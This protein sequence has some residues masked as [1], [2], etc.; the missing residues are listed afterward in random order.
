MGLF[1][2]AIRALLAPGLTPW[3]DVFPPRFNPAPLSQDGRTIALEIL[4]KYVCDLTFYREGAPGAPPIPFRILPANFHIEWPDGET[5]LK[6][7]AAVVMPA[8]GD[9]MTIGLAGY[10]EEDSRDKYARDT[11]L[12][13]QAE[14]NEVFNLEIRCDTRAERHALIAGLEIAFTPTEQMYG[15]RFVMRDYFNE[16]VCFSLNR[17]EN[18][19]DADSSRNRRRVQLEFEMR[20]TIVALVNSIPIYPMVRV[21]VNVDSDSFVPIDLES[22]PNSVIVP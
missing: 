21:D 5:E 8:R 13:W 4:K 22:D 6:H 20:F 16:L 19:D 1:S 2:K 18:I 9:Y 10:L 3:G 7:P 15:L 11:V 12:Q 14:Y 17:R